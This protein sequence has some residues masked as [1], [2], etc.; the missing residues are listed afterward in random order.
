MADNGSPNPIFDTDDSS[1]V[2]VTLPIKE[3]I[4]NGA[5]NGAI[6]L[7]FNT[8]ED[9]VAYSNAA[10]NGAGN[11][12]NDAITIINDAIH[13]RVV[14]VLGILREKKKRKEL[15]ELMGLSNQSKNRKK[16]LDPLIDI[17]WVKKEFSSETHP[18]QRYST[19]EP[20]L[21]ILKLGIKS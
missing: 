18:E 8:L 3:A 2:L 1:Y 17:G 15:F 5:D 19:T 9:V 16:F 10:G 6:D 7:I 12:A 13:D 21:K 20:G 14:E 4:D 11:G